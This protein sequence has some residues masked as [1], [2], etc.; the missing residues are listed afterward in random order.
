MKTE[1]ELM[2]EVVKAFLSKDIV[3]I[4]EF[5][6]KEITIKDDN[7]YL[8]KTGQY[9]SIVSTQHKSVSDFK[10]FWRTKKVKSTKLYAIAFDKHD[11]DGDTEFNI[12]TFVIY[13]GD[14]NKD[15]E[16]L[17]K[18]LVKKFGK[19]YSEIDKE[20]IVGFWII[21]ESLKKVF[22]NSCFQMFGNDSAGY[23][24]NATMKGIVK[25]NA[26]RTVVRNSQ[27]GKIFG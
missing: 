27:S 4:A 10:K 5:M 8:I 1:A 15:R 7:Q 12:D 13:N 23:V 25:G 11:I 24:E 14:L 26:I 6:G 19:K 9:D 17:F 20:K 2:R 21:D 16:E 22:D 18:E 3:A